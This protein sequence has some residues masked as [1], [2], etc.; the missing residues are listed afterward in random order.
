MKSANCLNDCGSPVREP[1]RVFVKVRQ[2]ERRKSEIMKKE[3]NTVE[4]SEINPATVLAR[5]LGRCPDWYWYQVNGQ[6]AQQNFQEQREKF[7]SSL[8]EEDDGYT[9]SVSSEV[10]TK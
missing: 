8:L 10:Q 2:S 3:V 5:K 7:I 9:V 1:D 4:N 6:S